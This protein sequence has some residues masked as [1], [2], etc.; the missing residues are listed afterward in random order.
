M[1][2]VLDHW[3][4]TCTCTTFQ[5]SFVAPLLRALG[6]KV[7][8]LF[9]NSLSIAV[10][11]MYN[12]VNCSYVRVTCAYHTCG[13]CGKSRARHCLVP[14]WPVYVGVPYGVYPGIYLGHCMLMYLSELFVICCVCTRQTFVSNSIALTYCINSFKIIDKGFHDWTCSFTKTYEL[15]NLV[16]T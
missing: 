3:T 4:C 5:V 15:T 1:F 9:T 8:C 13:V 11:F 14:S 2:A 7:Y 6:W 10:Y 16:L 12:M